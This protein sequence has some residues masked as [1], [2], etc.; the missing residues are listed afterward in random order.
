[1]VHG[2]TQKATHFSKKEAGEKM[3]KKTKKYLI[4]AL[5]GAL[6]A[7]SGTVIIM[8]L[9]AMCVPFYQFLT[10]LSYNGQGVLTLVDK[11]SLPLLIAYTPIGFFG[12][13][14]WFYQ[15]YPGAFLVVV[16]V[17]SIPATMLT[18]R[19]QHREQQEQQKIDMG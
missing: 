1:M 14:G 15:K 10:A 3:N 8:I 9:G 4:L 2:S 11:E 18:L 5:K 16:M 17:L 19:D 12:A 6:L 7:L 13:L